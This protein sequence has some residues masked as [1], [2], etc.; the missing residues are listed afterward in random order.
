MARI[1]SLPAEIRAIC[2]GYRKGAT[3][4][5]LAAKYDCSV[6]TIRIRLKENDEPLR[7]RGRKTPI[8]SDESICAMY[9]SGLSGKFIAARCGCSAYKIYSTL[10]KYRVKM[11]ISGPVH[12]YTHTDRGTIYKQYQH[13]GTYAKVGQI[14]GFSR[15][16]AHMIVSQYLE[17]CKT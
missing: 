12:T 2:N 15:Q 8:I 6:S 14:Y 4:L 9:E 17:E 16:R 10:R 1:L 3:L 5:Q 13:L 11:R 7:P